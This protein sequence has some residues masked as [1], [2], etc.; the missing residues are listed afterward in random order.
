MRE[1]LPPTKVAYQ[2]RP[3]CGFLAR[4]GTRLGPLV[5]AEL[6][7]DDFRVALGGLAY[8]ARLFPRDHTVEDA[9]ALAVRGL[10]PENASDFGQVFLLG[11]MRK[12][13]TV[14]PRREYRKVA[15]MHSY[16][17]APSRAVDY[18]RCGQTWQKPKSS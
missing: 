8:E 15:P 10:L 14:H 16:P 3:S 7:D 18:T 11:F 4:S 13:T 1:H 6:L 5:K 12:P 9:D 17:D 2:I